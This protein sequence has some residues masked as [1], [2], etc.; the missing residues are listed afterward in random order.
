MN[1]NVGIGTWAPG[2]ELIV[3]G[4][5]VGIGT[6]LPQNQNSVANLLVLQSSANSGMSI[7]SNTG[8]SSADIVFGNPT[9]PCK[10]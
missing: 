2:G 6:N 4:G 3:M 9:T 7:L 1:G 10:W 8:T 5:S